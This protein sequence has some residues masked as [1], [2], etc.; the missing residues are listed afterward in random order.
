MSGPVPSPSMK[1][2]IGWSGTSSLPSP[3]TAIGSAPVG[4]TGFALCGL[5]ICG[6]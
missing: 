4:M 1:G 5:D 3:R 2:M 6:C